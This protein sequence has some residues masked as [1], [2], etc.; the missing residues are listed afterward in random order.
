M[1]NALIIINVFGFSIVDGV[2]T[3]WAPPDYVD[4]ASIVP[5]VYLEQIPTWNPPTGYKYKGVFFEYIDN[6]PSIAFNEVDISFTRID[7]YFGQVTRSFSLPFSYDQYPEYRDEFMVLKFLNN[8]TN[9]DSIHPVVMAWRVESYTDHLIKGPISGSVNF[10]V[11]E[12]VT[13]F[14]LVA[15]AVAINFKTGKTKLHR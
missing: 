12:P 10:I 3:S 1:L 15:G 11:P 8:S 7:N 5:A 14:Y 9:Q 13:I 6:T 2:A 4:W